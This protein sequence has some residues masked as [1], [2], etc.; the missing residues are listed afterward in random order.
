MNSQTM[1]IRINKFACRKQ[2]EEKIICKG[3]SIYP[4]LT[5][6]SSGLISD[7]SMMLSKPFSAKT[8]V[9]SINNISKECKLWIDSISS[10]S[11][12][13]RKEI[14]KKNKIIIKWNKNLRVLLTKLAKGNKER[15]IKKLKKKWR[16]EQEG[17]KRI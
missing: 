16:L 11:F 9:N 10:I 5:S 7:K 14:I 17:T 3:Y 6:I 13:W 12:K 4:C 15:G 8:K 1:A 2:A